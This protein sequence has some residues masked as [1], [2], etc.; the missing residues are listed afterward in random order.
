MNQRLIPEDL[1][2]V[3]ITYIGTGSLSKGMT[4][5][6]VQIILQRLSTL[7]CISDEDGKDMTPEQMKD[8][9]ASVQQ[10]MTPE[11]RKKV[12]AEIE[13]AAKEPCDGDGTPKSRNAS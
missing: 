5:A 8:F 11:Q 2:Q 9:A 1:L 6:E 12:A 7:V 13:K 10:D 4:F 3:V